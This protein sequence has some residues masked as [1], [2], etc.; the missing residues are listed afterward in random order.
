MHRLTGIAV[1]L[2]T[3]IAIGAATLVAQ[4]ARAGY[5]QATHKGIE[6]MLGLAPGFLKASTEC[7]IAGASAAFK[8][9]QIGPAAFRHDTD[10]VL[11]LATEKAKTATGKSQEATTPILFRRIP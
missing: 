8:S 1:T 3:A 9:I 5:T 7:G 11:K 4:I 6:Q 2:A 10:T